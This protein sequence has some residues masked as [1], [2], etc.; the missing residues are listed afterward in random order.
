MS[1]AE[2][3]TP[4]K[5]GRKPKI[6]MSRKTLAL[7]GDWYKKLKEDEI[8]RDEAGEEF[9]YFKG[10][11]RL[12][13]AAGRISEQVVYC[14]VDKIVKPDCRYYNL[15]V[16]VVV[17]V[18]FSDGTVWC[19]SAD[20]HS[21]NSKKFKHHPTALA[22][23][24]AL[25]RAYR[26]ALG[27]HQVT[28]EEISDVSEEEM[29]GEATSQQVKLIEKLVKK[30]DWKPIDAIRLVTDRE[31]VTFAEF[32]REEAQVAARLLNE[33]VAK[34]T[35]EEKKEIKKRGRKAKSV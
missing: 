4:K 15:I 7:N 23:T 32:T 27:I 33:E 12:A 24:R 35:K 16:H 28:Y 2:V 20:A 26:R 8:G 30:L 25:G 31:M 21:G 29:T 17:E 11:A 3:A 9:V 13:E 19:G 22:E 18:K 1:D 14:H 10:L 34:K 5:R 6:D